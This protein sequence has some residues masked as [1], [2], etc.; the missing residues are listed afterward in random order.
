VSTGL[1][2]LPVVWTHAYCHVN[3]NANYQSLGKVQVGA[4]TFGPF[5]SGRPDTSRDTY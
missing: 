1:A 4:S 5:A 2:G 3:A